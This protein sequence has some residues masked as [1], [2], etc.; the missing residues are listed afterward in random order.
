MLKS[1]RIKHPDNKVFFISDL[2]YGHDRDFI[3]GPRGHKNVTEHDQAI[4]HG[5]NSVVDKHSIV[6]HLGDIMMNA[7]AGKFWALLHRLQF[8]ELYLLWGNHR[9][10]QKQAYLDCLKASHPG[11]FV[12]NDTAYEVYPLLAYHDGRPVFFLPQCVNAHINSTLYALCHFPIISHERQG[13]GSIHLCGH[14]H[15][16]LPLTNATTGKGMR[17]DVG[18]DS[19]GRPI[20]ALEIKAHLKNR[21][22]DGHDHHRANP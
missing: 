9:S 11:A 15:G 12:G 22:I 13:H 10:G 14:S 19:F 8:K 20:S 3:W 16:D 21:D 5:W 4:I 17:L 6:F 2:H 1:L 7:D 18:I